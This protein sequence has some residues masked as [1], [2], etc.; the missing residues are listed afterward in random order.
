MVLKT[1]GSFILSWNWDLEPLSSA[2]SE[3]QKP[4]THIEKKTKNQ[5]P[6]RLWLQFLLKD[7]QI[8]NPISSSEIF[9]IGT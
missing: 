3:A 9:P 6:S 2:S 5:H 4:R 7:I 8:S 1:T